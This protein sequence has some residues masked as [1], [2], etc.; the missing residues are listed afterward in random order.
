VVVLFLLCSCLLASVLVLSKPGRIFKSGIS[1]DSRKSRRY[2]PYGATCLWQH[3]NRIEVIAYA[4]G[5][6]DEMKYQV[7]LLFR[8]VKYIVD[9]Y[10]YNLYNL[11]R[12]PSPIY[13][14]L[15]YLSQD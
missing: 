8:L 4:F 15:S 14:L 5:S 9:I 6:M 1:Q 10:R 3:P 7:V 13:L 2:I 11:C 12:D